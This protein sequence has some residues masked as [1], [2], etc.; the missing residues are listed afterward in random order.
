VI[1]TVVLAVTFAQLAV[2]YLPPLQ[3]LLGTE[4][5]PLLHGAVIIASGLAFFAILEAEKQI[6]LGLGR[7][8]NPA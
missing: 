8:R 7:A 6:R 4:P 2:T 1:W 5:V 3:R